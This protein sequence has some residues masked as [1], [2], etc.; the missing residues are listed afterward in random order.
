MFY[1]K[2]M[3]LLELKITSYKSKHIRL[4]MLINFYLPILLHIRKK[5]DWLN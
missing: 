1:K 3:L 2:I 4:I 5:V